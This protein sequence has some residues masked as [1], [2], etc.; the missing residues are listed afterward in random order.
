MLTGD[1]LVDF[2]PLTRTVGVLMYVRANL[3][4]WPLLD[5]GLVGMILT[6]SRMLYLLGG[7]RGL[8][9]AFLH[10]SQ[11]VGPAAAAAT[12]AIWQASLLIGIKEDE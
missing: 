7:Q 5:A 8:D 1:N 9:R 6:H 12:M 10:L 3:A 2:G 11:H 4:G